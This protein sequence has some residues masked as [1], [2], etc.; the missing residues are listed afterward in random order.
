[1]PLLIVSCGKDETIFIP[2]AP[3]GDINYFYGQATPGA[4]Y[5]INFSGDKSYTF[6]ST[7]GVQVEIPALSVENIEG[8][9]YTSTV[10]LKFYEYSDISDFILHKIETRVDNEIKTIPN[11]MKIQ[12]T[13]TNGEELRFVANSNIRISIPATEEVMNDIQICIGKQSGENLNWT[14]VNNTSFDV[15]KW[16]GNWSY[17]GKNISGIQI[18]GFTGKEM[19][20]YVP[21]AGDGSKKIAPC[22]NLPELFVNS[23]TTVMLVQ[24]KTNTVVNLLAFA[25]DSYF[26]IPYKEIILGQEMDIVV[27][28]ALEENEFYFDVLNAYAVENVS[29]TMVPQQKSILEILDILGMF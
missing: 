21:T 14:S 1:M 2:D 9:L 15:Q 27:I 5:I 6:N 26:C 18:E 10:N 16:Y 13:G 3:K 17:D 28:S 12:L 22:V 29:L 24:G 11:A 4:D 19:G 23:N 20:I 8:N 25:E 7:T